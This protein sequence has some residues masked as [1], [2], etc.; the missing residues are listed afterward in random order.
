VNKS[1]EKEQKALSLFQI[2][3]SPEKSG[4]K[5]LSASE[6]SPASKAIVQGQ[7]HFAKSESDREKGK[8]K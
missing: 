1:G 4:E 5:E 3:F 7:F 6:S 2:S 8:K